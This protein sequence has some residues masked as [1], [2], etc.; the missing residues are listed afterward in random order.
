MLEGEGGEGGVWG[1]FGKA[2]VKGKR[3]ILLRMNKKRLS[4]FFVCLVIIFNTQD[5]M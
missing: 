3:E 4:V 2:R 1:V 5:R